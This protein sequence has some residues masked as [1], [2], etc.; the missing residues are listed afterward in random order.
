MVDLVRILKIPPAFAPAPRAPQA[1]VAQLDL[2]AGCADHAALKHFPHTAG[3]LA[4]ARHVRS[5]TSP[6]AGKMNVTARVTADDG[7]SFILK[8]SLRRAQRLR[9]RPS[10][11]GNLGGHKWGKLGGRQGIYGQVYRGREAN[12]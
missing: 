2:Q 12:H 6:G 3:W 5:V 7:T 9:P 11:W 10:G 8:Q 4:P 1:D